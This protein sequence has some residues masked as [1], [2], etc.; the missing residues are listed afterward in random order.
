MNNIKLKRFF[1]CSVIL[2]SL[3]IFSFNVIPIKKYYIKTVEERKVKE[4]GIA[5]TIPLG[6]NPKLVNEDYW[7]QN[8]NFDTLYNSFSEKKKTDVDEDEYF[9]GAKYEAET[10][11]NQ[12]FFEHLKKENPEITCITR[13][14]NDL[15]IEN[16][17]SLIFKGDFN[18]DFI[19]LK[20]DGYHIVIKGEKYGLINEK[21][22][23][24]IPIEYDLIDVPS[25][26]KVSAKKGDKWGY[27]NLK[28]QTVIP[29]HFGDAQLFIDG[30]AHV[31]SNGI[32]GV[33]DSMGN[34]VSNKTENNNW[35]SRYLV[36]I[37]NFN[38]MIAFSTLPDDN[39]ITF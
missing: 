17:N 16:Y 26:G 33:I 25:E 28:G 14:N 18:A 27:L 31:V 24:T 12:R 38:G 1:F 4:D 19:G 9:I 8:K 36:P 22:E 3:I 37:E 34:W 29:F 32:E 15:K 11:Q 10:K 2:G 20:V 30:Y 7:F 35:L 21:G 5:S 23:V 39:W 13:V 6:T